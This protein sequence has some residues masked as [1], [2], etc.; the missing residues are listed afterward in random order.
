M[1]HSAD[2]T[3]RNGIIYNYSKRGTYWTAGAYECYSNHL[4]CSHRC[5]NFMVC[6]HFINHDKI[7]PMKDIVLA[8][9]RRGITMNPASLKSDINL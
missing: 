7:P 1:H 5:S 2:S 9:I 8:L 6:K 4:T 3:I